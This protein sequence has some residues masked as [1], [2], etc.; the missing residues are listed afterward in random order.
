MNLKYLFN[1]WAKE[2][3]GK[4]RDQQWLLSK[5]DI[6]DGVSWP[7]DKIELLAGH[8]RNYLNL[9][10][11]RGNFLDLGCG[12]GWLLDQFGALSDM[13]V[14][15]DVAIEML[16]NAS[17]NFPLINGDACLMPF[18]SDSFDRILCYFVF[19][20]FSDLFL[21]EEALTQMV[22]VL[23]PGGV[24]LIGQLPDQE[25]S[26]MY[27]SEKKRYMDFCQDHYRELNSN[28]DVWHIPVQLFSRLF[29]E[30]ILT[31]LGCKVNIIPAFNPFYRAGEHERIMWRF[32]IVVEKK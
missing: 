25:K 23:K 27:E 15:C 20:N 19:I 8:I 6:L 5:W 3:D 10:P 30:Q 18:Q 16:K 24:A 2:S 21:V 13:S 7:Y 22:R 12:G 26:A 32:D 4:Y 9:H 31:R 1:N 29:F 14:G 17:G 11:N 28:R